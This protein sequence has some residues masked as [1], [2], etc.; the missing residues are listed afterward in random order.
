MMQYRLMVSDFDG[1][2]DDKLTGATPSRPRM[3]WDDPHS[4]GRCRFSDLQ[5]LQREHTR[6]FISQQFQADGE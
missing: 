2:A 5:D 4:T 6:G 3:E 1:M